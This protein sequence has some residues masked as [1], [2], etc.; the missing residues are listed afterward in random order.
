MKAVIM[1]GGEGSRL[2]PLTCDRPKPMVPVLNKPIMCHIVNLLKKH[3]MQNIG[4]T[5]QYMPEVIRDYFGSGAEYGVNFKYYIEDVPL[6]TAG[7]VKNAQDF[8]DET[9]LVISGDALTDLDLSQAIKFHKEKGSMASLVLTRVNSPLEYGV[10]ITREDGHIR[11]FLEKPSWGEVF[12]D[13]V[14]T[15]IYILEPEVL[16]YFAFGQKFDFSKDLF[17][18]LLRDGKPLYGVVLSGYWCDIGNINQYW[19][20]HQD[21]LNHK[22]KV[23]LHGHELFPGIRVGKNTE[24][25]PSANIEPPVFIGDNTKIQKDVNIDSYTVIGENTII[26]KNS[27]IKRS[28]LWNNVKIDPAVSLR[29]TVIGSRVEI[30]SNAGVYEQATIGSECQIKERCIIKPGVKL[31][32]QKTIEA[33]ATVQESIIWGTRQ[34]KKL[35][36]LEGISGKVNIELTPEFVTK[37]AAAYGSTLGNGEKVA[38]SCDNYHVSNMF[39]KAFSCG[40][41]SVGIEVHDL[42]KI[43]TPVHRFAVRSYNY[44]AGIH[45]KNSS[46]FNGV[47][48]LILTNEKGSNISRSK[49][50]KIENT[51]NK[52]DFRRSESENIIPG[53]PMAGIIKEYINFIVNNTQTE[54]LKNK[55]YKIVTAYDTHNL[56]TIIENLSQR[57]N[58]E[59][60]NVCAED[61]NNSWLEYYQKNVTIFSKKVISENAS[62]GVIIDNNADSLILIDEQGEIIQEDLLT[63]LIALIALKRHKEPVV[64]PVTASKTIESLAQKYSSKVI[65]TKTA[66]EDFSEQLFNAN[67]FSQFLMNF[68]ALA[69]F[70]EILDFVASEDILL[71]QIRQEIPIFFMDRKEVHV[72]WE[73]KGRVIRKLIEEKPSED[74]EMLDGVKAFHP[75]GWTL[76][77]P[78]PEE[79]VCRIF[80]E[81]VNMEVAESLAEFYSNKINDIISKNTAG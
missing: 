6:G 50:R 52:E 35:F 61:C 3:G 75:E 56:G 59:F 63:A 80:S 24:I 16:D 28:I 44:H 39:K 38:I 13:T 46:Q 32:P 15:G 12:S 25:H 5:L 60:K 22:V 74:L 62:M 78:D 76:V 27:S 45:I 57:L 23:E 64:V 36:G 42:G 29:G 30:K 77:L 49:E 69:A 47:I 65:R 9:F 37:L 41:Q 73:T 79:P 1:A 19:E 11:R 54:I 17:P 34:N 72:P 51:L 81:G 71:S 4:I 20:A 55:N 70:F 7:S 31:W 26:S 67:A 33:G 66:L 8:L 53:I 48:K 68:D 40:L 58:I 18:L 2:R 21:I 43:I 14:N 10:V